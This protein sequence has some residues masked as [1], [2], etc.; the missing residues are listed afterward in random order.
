M[1]HCL[2]VDKIRETVRRHLSKCYGSFKMHDYLDTKHERNI[3]MILHIP[4]H[5]TYS[6]LSN[7]HEISTQKPPKVTVSCSVGFFL[8]LE[9]SIANISIALLV[10][11]IPGNVDCWCS[12]SLCRQNINSP[13]IDNAQ[14]KYLCLPQG[15]TSGAF[16]LSAFRNDKKC[17][18]S[19]TYW[20]CHR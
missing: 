1:A 6:K 16:T 17:Y 15:R 9:K 12:G 13:D 2:L 7:D 10:R 19:Q 4:E 11:N 14:Y 18:F 5:K 8:I 20:I 3:Y